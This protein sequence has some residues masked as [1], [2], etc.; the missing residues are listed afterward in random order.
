M[1][2]TLSDYLDLITS[3]H[4]RRPKFRGMVASAVAPLALTVGMVDT[5]AL[6]AWDLDTAVGVQLDQ[7]G[8]WIGATRYIDQPLTD[9][10]FTWDDQVIT[11]WEHGY[12][13][14]KYDPDTG[15]VQLGDN[16]YRRVLYA[17]IKSN[18]WD[19]TRESIEA[20]WNDVFGDQST[21][22]IEDHQ[23]MTMTVTL[24]GVPA[25]SL[26]AYILQT[27]KIPLKPEGVGIR[28]YVIKPL[29]KFAFDLTT[30]DYAGFDQGD[31]D[32]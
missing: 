21:L 22:V 14:G 23:D 26:L 29:R 4:R 6:Q 30:I 12:W 11:G 2:M 3:Q 17:K 31:W 25:T 32:E 7:V 27:E 28:A 15:L 13:Q 20:I 8:E 18:N 10:Y 9:F 19:G 24:A 1:S 16:I 5:S